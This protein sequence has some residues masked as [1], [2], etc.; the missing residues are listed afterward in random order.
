VKTQHRKPISIITMKSLL[1]GVGDS[2]SNWRKYTKVV[3]GSSGSVLFSRFIWQ[4]SMALDL[5]E[6]RTGRRGR[7]GQN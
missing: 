5:F 7:M 6:G 2:I 4:S 1:F 3:W